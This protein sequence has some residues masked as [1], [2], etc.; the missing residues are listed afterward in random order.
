[1][2]SAIPHEELPI[3]EA[4]VHIRNRLTALKKDSGE[5]IRP[6]DVIDIYK[7]VIKQGELLLF[8]SQDHS[9]K[10]DAS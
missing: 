8:T 4:L 10:V 3:V 7:A 2:S 6:Q 1:M 5:Y 9:C